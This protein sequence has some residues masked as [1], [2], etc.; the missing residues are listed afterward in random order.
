MLHELENIKLSKIKNFDGYHS[1][2]FHTFFMY[3]ANKTWSSITRMINK[4]IEVYEL[5]IYV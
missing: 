1:R 4:K 2:I 3:Y 5:V